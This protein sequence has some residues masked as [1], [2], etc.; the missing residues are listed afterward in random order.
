M[1]PQAEKMV[2]LYNS[3]YSNWD[4]DVYA[5]VRMATY[6]VDFGQTSWVS[7][8][9]SDDI[10][11]LLELNEGSRVLEIGCG[12]GRYALHL[13]QKT[14][15]RITAVD[16]NGFGIS[17][18][19]ELARREGLDALA[20][21]EE[22]DVSRG[23]PFEDGHFDAVFSNDVLCHI[24][25]RL[26]VLREMARVTR[27][28]GRL[29]FSDALIIGGLVTHEE[30]ATRSSIGLYVFSPP[31]FNEELIR[32]SGLILLQT[33]DT[34]ANAAE[35]ARRWHAARQQFEPELVAA[36]GQPNFDG[37]QRFLSC[38]HKLLLE[39]RL[40]RCLYVVQ[41]QGPRTQ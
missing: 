32:E 23:L 26:A 24:P 40:R 25:D 13:A 14:R 37:L 8:Q 31:G 9:E 16:I 36:E 30:L 28:G 7:L 19:R 41:K 35:V 6:G 12:S 34:T 1:I 2:D 20:R 3:A 39:G 15:C 11:Q 5:Q 4:R 17:A 33:S 38:V 27:K 21:F 22:C 10:P 18:G 29:L